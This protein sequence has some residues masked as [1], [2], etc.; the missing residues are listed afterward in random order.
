MFSYFF[1]ATFILSLPIWVGAIVEDYSLSERSGGFI[2][3]IE[4]GGVAISMLLFSRYVHLVNKRSVSLV[5]AVVAIAGNLVAALADPL[6]LVVALR[7]LVGLLAGRGRYVLSLHRGRHV[8][9]S[10]D[11]FDHGDISRAHGLCF[12]LLCGRPGGKLWLE[13]CLRRRWWLLFSSVF[14][15]SFSSPLRDSPTLR[16]A[17]VPGR[18]GSYRVERYV[19][20]RAG[21]RGH[22]QL[23]DLR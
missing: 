9:R 12:L 18:L 11:L 17:D 20:A 13:R 19:R 7:A 21:V 1:G 14:R 3:S 6:P 2:G 10:A 15:S 22:V 4:L 23:L 8:T 5:A 16:P